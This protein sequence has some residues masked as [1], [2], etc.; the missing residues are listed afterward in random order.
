MQLIKQKVRTLGSLMRMHEYKVQDS[1]KSMLTTRESLGSG[2][3]GFVP[4]IILPSDLS[5]KESV[6]KNYQF[7][8]W[9]PMEEASVDDIYSWHYP[10]DPILEPSAFFLSKEEVAVLYVPT[11]I[12]YLFNT[13]TKEELWMRID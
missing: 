10:Q 13:S 5:I 4:E 9:S 7:G 3:L 8:S 11:A 6:T 1:N 12:L 2:R